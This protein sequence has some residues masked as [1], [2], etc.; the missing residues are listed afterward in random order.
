MRLNWTNKLWEGLLTIVMSLAWDSVERQTEMM[1]GMQ[2]NREG[3]RSG[4]EEKESEPEAEGDRMK[5]SER[6]TNLSFA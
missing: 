2:S 5:F 4:A 1:T 6:E 3:K